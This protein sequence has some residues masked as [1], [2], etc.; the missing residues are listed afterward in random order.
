MTAREKFK[1][2]QRVRLSWLGL[3][4]FKG[5]KLDAHTRATVVGY[6]R[7]REVVKVQ[8]DGMQTITSYR[9]DL[10]EVDPQLLLPHIPE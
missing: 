2:G 9:A 5:S 6:G 8:R 3:K 10:W 4:R 1:R 7:S